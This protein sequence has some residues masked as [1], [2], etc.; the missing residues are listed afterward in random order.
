MLT[1][2]RF[3][4][5]FKVLPWLKFNIS[6]S[7]IS[8]TLGPDKAHVTV[9]SHGTYFYMD[10]PGKGTYFQRKLGPMLDD[11]NGKDKSD[12]VKADD[13]QTEE[14]APLI[15]LGLRDKLFLVPTESYFVD[16]LKALDAEDLS[17]AYE[18]AQASVGLADGA[19]L[20]GFL[21]MR[22]G[23]WQA[24]VD[25]F[26]M[27]LDKQEYLGVWCT[28]LGVNLKV[29]LP[30]SEDFMVA[31]QP[32]LQDCLL[33]LAI[34]HEHCGNNELAIKYLQY[35]REQHDPENLIIRLLLAELIDGTYGDELGVQHEIV[36][37]AEGIRNESPLHATLM[38]YR[39]RALRR[40]N[41]LGGARDTITQALRKEKNYP[42][43]LLAALRYE[44][45][46]I[47]EKEGRHKRARTEFEKI[48]AVAPELEDV[49]ERLGLTTKI[50]Q[51]LPE[52]IHDQT[53]NANIDPAAEAVNYELKGENE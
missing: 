33:A 23:E 38:Y 48:Y 42:P 36:T 8:A 27:A 31:V 7:G 37:L 30:I 25:Y 40:M 28:K 35:I 24:A 16:A 47:Y 3:R 1:G 39:A 26:S 20:A 15:E 45:A 5:E 43:E 17:R 53:P 9:G 49:A 10:L 11:L 32:T 19:F 13:Q 52:P 46:L 14:N 50:N 44:R 51:P 6:K 21:A 18:F 34:A 2:F 22:H 4:R 29:Y 12:K 41:V